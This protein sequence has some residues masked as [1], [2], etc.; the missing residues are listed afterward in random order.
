[1]KK[2][3]M[4]AMLSSLMVM[5]E[6][7]SFSVGENPRLNLTNVSGDITVTAG[8]SNEVVVD[9]EIKDDRIEVS[10][11]Q[12]GDKIDVRVE[13]PNNTRNI[14][15]GVTFNVTFPEQGRL[16]LTTVSGD[17]NVSGISGDLGMTA[18]SGEIMLSGA[19]G[20]ISVN[21]VS[22]KVILDEMGDAELKAQTVSGKL[23]YAGNLGGGDY[24]F[25]TVS[26][27]LELDIDEDA[28]FSLKG[29]TMNGKFESS[30]DGI[31]VSK[32][33]Y[34]GFKNAKGSVNGGDVHVKVSSV[35]GSITIK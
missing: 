7:Q 18:V 16:R 32:E 24:K 8:P 28:S 17:I 30:F 3:W 15:G 29:N 5:A 27:S 31:E 13:Y 2:F 10:V 12:D 19:S 33:Q 14:D 6:T 21:S 9:W 4:L 23:T 34:T 1:M 25:S 22:G 35:N 11:E 26:G 20:D